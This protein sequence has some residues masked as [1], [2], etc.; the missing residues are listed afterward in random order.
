MGLARERANL[1]SCGLP[2]DVVATIQGARAMST[3]NAYDV[4]WNMFASWC[5]EQ[6]PVVMAFQASIVAFSL[7]YKE[8]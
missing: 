6:S 1:S 3:R 8:G 7:F 5:L 2:A 4:R